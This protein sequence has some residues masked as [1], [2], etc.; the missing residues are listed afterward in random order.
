MPTLSTQ[1]RP[2]QLD[3]GRVVFVLAYT[4]AWIFMVYGA[5]LVLR[6]LF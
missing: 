3:I 1:S 5:Q 2:R 6:R 4:A